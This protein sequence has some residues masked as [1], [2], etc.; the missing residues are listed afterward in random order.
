MLVI[1][2]DQIEKFIR[3]DGDDFVEHLVAHRK[4]EDPDIV[5][6]YDDDQLRNMVRIGINKAEN[7]G[8]Q[9]S[10][11]QSAFVAIMFEIAPNFDTQP[12]INVVLKDDSLD[13]EAKFEKLWSPAV[14]DEAWEKAADEYDEAAWQNPP[15]KKT[16][17]KK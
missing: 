10:K 11:D 13:A 14:P 3:G 16:E 6:E 1:R 8:F 17:S 7:Y 5:T 2:N 12:E 9:K 15:K 4:K